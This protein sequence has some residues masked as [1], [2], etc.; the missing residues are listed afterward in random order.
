MNGTE[1]RFGI[2][3]FVTITD[4]KCGVH[5][6]F[7]SDPSVPNR[8]LELY[9]PG[10]HRVSKSEFYKAFKNKDFINGEDIVKMTILYFI[11][12]F[13]LGTEPTKS[14]INKKYV[15]LVANGEYI[16]YLWGD[17]CFQIFLHTCSHRL[18]RNPTSFFYGGFYLAAQIWFYECC[19]KV[20]ISVARH[21]EKRTLH[22]LNWLTPSEPIRFK[23]FRETMFRCYGNQVNVLN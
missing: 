15:D 19:S 5:S 18:D 23:Y 3:E 8:L 17:E 2:R 22:I 7:V 9:F 12:S 13:L 20:D 11:H 21:V 10:K 14:N 6:E 4:L 1:L 16:K